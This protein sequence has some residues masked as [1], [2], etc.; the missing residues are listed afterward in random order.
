MR[1]E[2]F[3]L[4]KYKQYFGSEELFK[5]F[6]DVLRKHS[7]GEGI[8]PLVVDGSP[9]CGLVSAEEVLKDR[10][11]RIIIAKPQILAELAERLQNETPE[12]WKE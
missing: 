8:T 4:D 5:A 1:P 10:I 9:V 12:E 6:C 11:K 3:W 2:P 7:I